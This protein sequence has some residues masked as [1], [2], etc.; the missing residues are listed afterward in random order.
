MDENVVIYV[1]ESLR[2]RLKARAA[3][4]KKTL[5]EFVAEILEEALRK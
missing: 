2:D 1:P 4:L 5:Q 3:I